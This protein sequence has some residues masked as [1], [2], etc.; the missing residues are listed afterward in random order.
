MKFLYLDEIINLPLHKILRL[1][2]Q[3]PAA[4]GIATMCFDEKK[5]KTVRLREY[6]Y[7]FRPSRLPI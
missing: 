3:R 1:H 4:C 2:L 6:P 5:L 7:C